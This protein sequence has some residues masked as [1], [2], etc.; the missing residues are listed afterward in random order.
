[1]LLNLDKIKNH[2]FNLTNRTGFVALFMIFLVKN[3]GPFW[4]TTLPSTKVGVMVSNGATISFTAGLP[5]HFGVCW[6]NWP[7][8]S[9]GYCNRI[10]P[11]KDDANSSSSVFKPHTIT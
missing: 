5:N 6:L 10:Y 11:N 1:L 8:H 2:N 4:A 9:G 7:G 3:H